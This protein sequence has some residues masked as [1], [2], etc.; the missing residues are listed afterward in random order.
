MA[1]PSPDRRTL[2]REDDEPVVNDGNEP[3]SP[4]GIQSVE[5]GGQLLKALVRAGRALPLGALAR[6][7]GMTPAKAHPYLVS[8]GKLG[9]IAQDPVSGSYGLGPLALQLGLIGLQ[10]VDP[11]RL[12]VAELPAL[13]QAVGCTVSAAVWGPVGPIIVHVERGPTAVH[14]AMRHGTP[15]SL[16][17][18]GTGKIFAAFA[19]TDAVAEALAREGEAAAL[20]DPVFAAEL[21]SIR[22]EG[23]SRVRDELL[24]GISAMAVPVFDG[25]GQVVLAIAAIA[26][27]PLLDLSTDSAQARALRAASQRLSQRLGAPAQTPHPAA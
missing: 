18:T 3:R 14:V 25:L 10:Q 15:A 20:T 1:A 24:P 2:D 27:S 26:P 9:L 13:A 5:V 6:A 22:R 17:H 19:P 11:V 23:L 4:R 21:Q 8:F 12:A 7:A 16:R